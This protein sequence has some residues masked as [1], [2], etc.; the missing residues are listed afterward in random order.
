MAIYDGHVSLGEED[1]H[2]ILGLGPDRATLS[3][4]GTEIGAWAS[5]EI[6]ITYQGQGV[7]SISAEEEK[8]SFTPNDQGRFAIEF[9]EVSDEADGPLTDDA[10]PEAPGGAMEQPGPQYETAPPPK[11]VTRVVFYALAGMTAALGLW[12]VAALVMG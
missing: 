9:R 11:A 3:S 12:A 6:S 4:N 1:V 8:L 7:Y 5:D 10:K 2:V